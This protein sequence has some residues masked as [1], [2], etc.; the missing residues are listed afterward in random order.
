M[1]ACEPNDRRCRLVCH[2]FETLRYD[3]RHQTNKPP[4]YVEPKVVDIAG[5]RD[6]VSQAVNYA[7]L[8]R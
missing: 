3:N 5:V 8:K 2:M 1:L 6:Y 7:A 4:V